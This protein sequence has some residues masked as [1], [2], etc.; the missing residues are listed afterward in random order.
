MIN[1]KPKIVG[2]SPFE[3]YIYYD[4]KNAVP[5]CN[6]EK[7]QL[8]REQLLAKYDIDYESFSELRY[9]DAENDEHIFMGRSRG[10]N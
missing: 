9:Y 6:V 5:F 3:I 2:G 8:T 7:D 4:D 10:C 1:V